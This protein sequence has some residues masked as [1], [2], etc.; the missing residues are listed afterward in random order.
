MSAES[1]GAF[2]GSSSAG[3]NVSWTIRSP[4]EPDAG[5]PPLSG[6]TVAVAGPASP[7]INEGRRVR[8]SRNVS[9]G[10][11]LSRW[12]ERAVAVTTGG[13][14]VDD[15]NAPVGLKSRSVA[16]PPYRYPGGSVRLTVAPPGD[17]PPVSEN[18]TW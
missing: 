17:G 9:P 18:P 5:V 6:V 16:P 11:R 13:A 7:R 15:V 12:N 2:A 14:G 3:S 10:T 8:S 1:V 4:P